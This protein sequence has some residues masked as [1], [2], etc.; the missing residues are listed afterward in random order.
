[1]SLVDPMCHPRLVS[2][3]RCVCPRCFEDSD[4]KARIRRDGSKGRCAFCDRRTCYALPV[5]E[6]AA[7]IEERMRAFYGSAVDQLPYDSREGGYQG[8]TWDTW[9]LLF[10]EIGLCLT[11]EDEDSL[12]SALLEHI[13]DDVW[14]E[15]DWLVLEP[16]DSMRSSW[17]TF[18]EVTKGGRRFFFHAFGGGDRYRGPDE[19]TAGEFLVE[20]R[21]TIE[22]LG[23]VREIDPGTSLFRVRGQEDPP[24][25]LVASQLGPPPAQV[26]LQS[27]RMNPPGIPMF[28]GAETEQLALREADATRP[29]M[30]RFETVRPLRIIDLA[31]LPDP[32]G[33]F[34]E[35]SREDI[36]GLSFLR[37]LSE[38]FAEPVERSNRVN[39]DYIP[40]QIVTEFLR[41]RPFGG[42]PVQGIRYVSAK[43]GGA[44]VVLFTG[45][46][47]VADL[48]DVDE[49][50]WLVL[51]AAEEVDGA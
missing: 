45:E 37:S 19:R 30:A 16:D 6:I 25:H 50:T 15:Y 42:Q 8:V 12:R 44:N 23:L 40:T 26:C 43:G 24:F 4:L 51:V 5:D 29:V 2:D 11:T 1:M 48:G 35:A 32:R 14:C 13:E 17:R 22:R 21:Q 47:H 28:Y 20:L 46:G 36:K 3:E 41:D 49:A 7:F 31:S 38:A 33:F 34:S 9:D 10:D 39:V 18:C 27:N